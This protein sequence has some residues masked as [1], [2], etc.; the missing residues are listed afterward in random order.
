MQ[1]QYQWGSILLL[2][3][4]YFLALQTALAK[5]PT[6]DEAV[7]IA[8]GQA[9]W[10]TQDLGIQIQPPSSH[11]LIGSLLFLEPSKVDIT[12][13]PSW[14][15][16]D[17][18]SIG[19]EF[20][21]E[22]GLNL[23]RVLLFARLPILFL[24]MLL[25]A[26]LARW[27]YE[28]WG[29]DS[30]LLILSLFAFSPN[31]IA[32][33]SLATTDLT[34]A[35]TFTFSLYALW[36]Y[37]QKATWGRWLVAGICLGLGIAA[38]LT[39]ILLLPLTLIL[40]YHQWKPSRKWWQPA[41]LWLG[42]LPVAGLVVWGL[43]HWEIRLLPNMPF[44]L[45]AATYLSNF[46][47][48]QSH[49]VR[50]HPTY[51][52]GQQSNNG[53]WYY[54]IVAFFIKTPLPILLLLLTAVSSQ[55]LQRQWKSTF[56]LWFPAGSLFIIA[57]YSRLNIGYRHILPI[58][59]F[60]WL[61]I[62]GSITFWTKH[63]LWKAGVALLLIWYL[64]GTIQ[65]HPHHLAYFNELTGGSEQGFRYL[66][67]SNLDWGQDLNLLADYMNEIDD[68]DIYVSYFGPSDLS[69][70]NLPS[71]TLFTTEG[72]PVAFAPAN[73]APG[74]YGISASHLQGMVLAEPD[75][76]DWFR[77]QE[78]VI[79]L[80]HSIFIYDIPQATTGSW[81][82]HCLNPV[83]ILDNAVAAQLINQ[84]DSR[85]I[86]FDCFNS[87]VFPE[88]GQSG[89]YILPLRDEEWPILDQ[90]PGQ[91]S[92][93]YQ[94]N[95]RVPAYDVYYWQGSQN[96]AAQIGTQ[97]GIIQFVDG[98]ITSP[99]PVADLGHFLGYWTDKSMWATVWQVNGLTDEPVSIAGHL[100][101]D[102]STPPNIADG[103]G[104]SA[105]QWQAGDIFVQYHQ[106]DT[107][108]GEPT[109]YLET[110][111]Y[112]YVTGEPILFEVN[113]RFPHRIRLYPPELPN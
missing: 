31:I 81:I 112:N 79:H 50:G 19:Y 10:Q 92:H 105:I 84:P 106:F 14:D 85:H 80:G 77:R 13:L 12:H 52:L 53:W 76:F 2:L 102:G 99:I 42:L 68:V 61:L 70:Y 96:L 113:G 46:L 26:V 55:I 93:V 87:W 41:L 111:F 65:Q 47:E 69:Y 63:Y 25:G 94:H 67:D 6:V 20:L 78:P 51:L 64:V 7:H 30:Q 103:L 73:P 95:N 101:N 36:R 43:Y 98:T 11:W 108:I 97:N 4:F 60:V 18:P 9:L 74:M 54:F 56:F 58:L 22:S 59:P 107:S 35:A 100:Y 29:G 16:Y 71:Q 75:M 24:A 91:F 49:L 5:S 89:W 23:P 27:S 44:P 15:S 21:W 104:Y 109:S 34:T 3:A 37:G 86:T 110:G 82:A 17:R 62:T 88:N 8:R 39:S 40:A 72:E 83:P 32:S 33:A 28:W 1:R 90:F 45:P 57:S 66:G 38:K 48:A